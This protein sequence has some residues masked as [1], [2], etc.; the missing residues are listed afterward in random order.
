M[1]ITRFFPPKDAR[2][3]HVSMDRGRNGPFVLYSEH[4]EKMAELRHRIR[5]LEKL[6]EVDVQC[7]TMTQDEFEAGMRAA[8]QKFN[9]DYLGG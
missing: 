7:S 3:K 6:L 9:P 2:G 5:E 4:L 1:A 8:Q